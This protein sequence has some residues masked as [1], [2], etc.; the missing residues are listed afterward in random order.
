MML[1]NL[2]SNMGSF[3]NKKPNIGGAMGGMDVGA[4]MGKIGG[5]GL[6]SF[7]E[8]YGKKNIWSDVLRPTLEGEVRQRFVDPYKKWYDLIKSM[9]EGTK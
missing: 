3:L 1:F 5:N 8:N 9:R 6:A 2:L 4:A 7:L